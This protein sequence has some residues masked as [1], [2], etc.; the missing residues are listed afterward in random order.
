[1][2]KGL[3]QK[4]AD[5]QEYNGKSRFGD[6]EGMLK[7]IAAGSGTTTAADA[8]SFLQSESRATNGRCQSKR[9]SGSNGDR[10]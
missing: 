8:Q 7:R 6:D 4:T 5:C 3:Q 10:R 1:M 9:D 2:L